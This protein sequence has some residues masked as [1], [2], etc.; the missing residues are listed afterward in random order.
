MIGLVSLPMGITIGAVVWALLHRGGLG[1]LVLSVLA[2]VGGAV[3][4]A[5]TGQALAAHPEAVGHILVGS[6]LGSIFAIAV[7]VVALGRRPFVARTVTRRGTAPQ[8]PEPRA[9]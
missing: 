3:I 4:G 1:G 7:A 2:G 8:S 9:T 5:Y 6:L